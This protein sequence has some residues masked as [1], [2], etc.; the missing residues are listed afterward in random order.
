MSRIE[1]GGH[2]GSMPDIAIPDPHL[3]ENLPTQIL[4]LANDVPFKKADLMGL[5]YTHYEVWC[6][7]AAGGL[8]GGVF[9]EVSWPMVLSTEPAPPDIWNSYL[10]QMEAFDL[11]LVPP[12]RFY[13]DYYQAVITANPTVFPAG[14]LSVAGPPGY[15]GGY[16]YELTHYQA[17]EY[18]NPQHLLS[19]QTYYPPFSTQSPGAFG[20]A[21]GGGGLHVVSGA[22]ADLPDECAV[23]V[24]TVG[25]DA[26][27]G[28]IKTNGL[29][30]PPRPVSD[31][32]NPVVAWATRY[33]GAPKSYA[34]PQ[35]GGDGGASSFGGDIC[36]ASG[37]KGGHGAVIWV[38]DA[39]MVDGGG[40]EGGVG[41]RSIPGG[42]AAGGLPRELVY[43]PDLKIS[44]QN[45][46]WD[47]TVGQGGGGGRGGTYRDTSNPGPG[48]SA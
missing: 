22:L 33:S 21:G 30:V 39:L 13:V 28:Q 35:A 24:G 15:T 29:W 9:G 36:Q 18:Y 10:A 43:N 3:S 38:D 31:L 12:K 8:G 23:V 2:E 19:V 47:G 42:G 25:A 27:A 6:V 4:E 41:G 40:G 17:I 7:G 34:P 46:T 37:G 16:F 5:G 20:G 44:G 32:S 48:F 26:D 14:Y 1:F 11:H 45:G